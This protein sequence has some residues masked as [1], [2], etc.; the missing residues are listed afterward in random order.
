LEHDQAL[1]IA[2]GQRAKKS[3]INQAKD[4]GVGADA[5]G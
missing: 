3:G 4:G 1:R 2:H 5:E